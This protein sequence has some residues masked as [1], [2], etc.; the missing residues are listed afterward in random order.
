MHVGT[1]L[2]GRN[3]DFDEASNTFSI[4]GIP[5][6][7]DRLIAYDRGGQVHWASSELRDWAYRYEAIRVEHVGKQQTAQFAAAAEHEARVAEA[8]RRARLSAQGYDSSSTLSLAAQLR[9][10]A[11]LLIIG[12]SITGATFGV[13]AGMLS[14]DAS[15][16][17]I[18]SIVFGGVG[19]LWGYLSSL[20]LKAVAH[21]LST[22]VQIEM[23][24]RSDA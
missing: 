17:M 19:L 15:V 5:S 9:G 10:L 12:A 14:G 21:A 23:N 22:L 24:T 13:L 3:I 7:V 18:A 6:T 2:D 4:G 1:D 20:G 16:F 11:L 8:A